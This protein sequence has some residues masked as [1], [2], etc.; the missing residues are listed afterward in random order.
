MQITPVNPIL[1]L[2]RMIRW[3]R[4]NDPFAP[5]WESSIIPSVPQSRDECDVDCGS[6]EVIDQMIA[7][8]VDQMRVNVR[9]SAVMLDEGRAQT[10]H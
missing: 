1:P 5:D 8:A 9:I 4:D 3:K 2:P 7:R 6:N 10:S